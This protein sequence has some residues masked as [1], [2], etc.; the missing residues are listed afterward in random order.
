MRPSRWQVVA[1][2]VALCFLTGVVGWWIGRPSDPS[3][4]DVDVGF[5]SDMETHHGGAISLAFAYIAPRARLARRSDRAGDRPRT[6]AGDLGDERLPRRGGPQKGDHRRRGDGLDGSCGSDLSDAGHANQRGDGGASRLAGRHG[7][8]GL[9]A[10]HD[11]PPCRGRR[12]GRLC[13][14]A[15]AR[16]RTFASLAAAMAKVQRSEIAELNQRRRTLGFDPVDAKA[17]EN[18][19]AEHTN[20]EVDQ[21]HCRS[22]GKI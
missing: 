9:H 10:A 1:L 17:L 16:T 6:I 8:R 4:N 5:L 21:R 13:R 11:Q 2:V 15:R 12:D 19:H 7:G 22:S 20:L 14:H 3:F 18:L